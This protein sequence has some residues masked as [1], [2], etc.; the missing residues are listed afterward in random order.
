MVLNNVALGLMLGWVALI[1]G[2][3]IIL[4]RKYTFNKEWTA[5]N[6]NPYANETLGMPRGVMRS[7]LTL[8]I[9]F[10]VL[11]LEVNSLSFDP[12]DL[13]IGGRIF[14]P[15]DRFERLMVAF[16]MMI[17]FYF[18]SKMVHH[19]VHNERRIAE[20][21]AE[22]AVEEARAKAA[23]PGNDFEEQGAQG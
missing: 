17:S 19:V 14:I 11:L 22:S 23:A 5:D 8:S 2:F 16:Q 15:E 7:V 21:R 18:G 4:L 6:P 20:K 10:V 9:L 12:K 3:F 1:I 13:A